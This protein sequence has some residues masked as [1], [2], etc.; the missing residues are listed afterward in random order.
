MSNKKRVHSRSASS[1]G[2]QPAGGPGA[3]IL[4]IAVGL[5]VV[6][7]VVSAI[8]LVERRQR[9]AAAMTGALQ[10]T[11]SVPVV[12]AAP[13]PTTELPFPGVARISVKDTKELMDKGEALLLDARSKASYDQAHAAGAMSFPEE[14]FDAEYSKLPKDKLLVLYCT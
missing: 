12:T 5:V 2:K 3:L 13:L 9:D 11:L 6:V 1:K 4:P 7:F 8:V 10:N 14:T